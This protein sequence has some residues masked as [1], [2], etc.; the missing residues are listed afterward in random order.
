MQEQIFTAFP[1]CQTDD[2]LEEYTNA[3]F[4]IEDPKEGGKCQVHV[5]EN[6][7]VD[8]KVINEDEKAIHFLAIDKCLLDDSDEEKCDFALFDDDV[9]CF[10]EIK[11]SKPRTRKLRRKKA[12]SQLETTITLFQSKLDFTNYQLEANVC[13]SMGTKIFPQRNASSLANIKRFQDKY[14]TRLTE[15]NQNE[16]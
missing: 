8:F 7:Q 12:L 5:E 1:K 11:E 3:I 6:N 16:F 9:F 13:F 4:W 10:I 2:C 15:G 14:N